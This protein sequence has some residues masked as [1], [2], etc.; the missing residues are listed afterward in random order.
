MLNKLKCLGY[1]LLALT[2]LGLAI[3][4]SGIL[5]ILVAIVSA[6]GVAF[7]IFSIVVY[8]VKE[9]FSKKSTNY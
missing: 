8:T 7:L 4:L 5:S 6:A 1:I 9:V 2:L 3:A